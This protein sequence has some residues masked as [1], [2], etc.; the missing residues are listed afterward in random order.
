MQTRLRDPGG[1]A[2]AL[3][4]VQRGAPG[5]PTHASSIH[6]GGDPGRKGG[7]CLGLGVEASEPVG[8]PQNSTRAHPGL[9][10]LGLA[11]GAGGAATQTGGI[12]PVL[13]LTRASG[14]LV[15]P[16]LPWASAS[17]SLSW[18]LSSGQRVFLP[19]A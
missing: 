13:P 10:T 2:E 8:Y 6:V 9:E 19:K 4:E 18:A 7:R 3:G 14:P 15:Q 5:F 11:W 12:C 16:T 17:E 1:D